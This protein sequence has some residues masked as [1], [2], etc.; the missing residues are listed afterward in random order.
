MSIEGCESID[1]QGDK[2]KG[3]RSMLLRFLNCKDIHLNDITLL[4]SAAWT[5]LL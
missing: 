5:S 1:G 2:F 3:Q 4:S